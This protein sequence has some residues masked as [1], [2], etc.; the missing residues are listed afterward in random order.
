MASHYSPP[1]YPQTF[2]LNPLEIP[3]ETNPLTFLVSWL[4]FYALLLACWLLARSTLRTFRRLV[5]RSS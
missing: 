1:A 5:G 4:S 2:R 3:V